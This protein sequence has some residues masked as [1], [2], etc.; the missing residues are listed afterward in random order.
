[1][2]TLDLW[3]MMGN[4]GMEFTCAVGWLSP[5]IQIVL[6]AFCPALFRLRSIHTNQIIT[7]P[8]P[9]QITSPANNTTTEV[10]T[11]IITTGEIITS[12]VSIAPPV[13]THNTGSSLAMI[14]MRIM[15]RFPTSS[16]I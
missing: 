15:S 6:F 11:N 10:P 1:M 3:D 7:K 4:P 5:I 14:G 13:S 9:R 8:V 16:V 12:T 2:E